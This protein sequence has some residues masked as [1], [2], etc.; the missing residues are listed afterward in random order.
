MD[1]VATSSRALNK[2]TMVPNARVGFEICRIE[3]GVV[4]VSPKSNRH[5]WK[6]PIASEFTAFTN[7]SLAPVAAQD[8]NITS[9]NRALNFASID[10]L[11]ADGPHQTADEISPTAN[12]GQRHIGFH[13]IVNEIKTLFD[14]RTAGRC[15]IA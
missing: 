7:R 14:Q 11:G 9:Q 10:G 4:L 5:G 3:F 6:W 12:A 13:C 8:L 1:N 15:N 2:V